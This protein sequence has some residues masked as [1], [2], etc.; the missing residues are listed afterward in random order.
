MTLRGPSLRILLATPYYPPA[1]SF[2]GPVRMAEVMVADLLTAGHEVT[3]ATTDVMDEDKRVPPGTAGGPDGAE[4]LRFANVSHRVAARAAGFAPR[5]YR[6]WLRGNA[7]RFDLV[8]L[9]DLYSM[10]SVGAARSAKRAGVPYIV[11]PFGSVAP[12]SERGKPLVKRAFLSLWGRRTLR[13][14]ST[15]IHSTV[16]ERNDFLAAGVPEDA[17]MVGMPLPL[18]LPARTG[19]PLAPRPTLAFVGRLDPIKGLDRMLRAVDIARRSVTGLHM[20]IVGPGERHRREMEALAESLGLGDVVTFR[21]FV[22]PEEKVRTLESA[23]A[24]C[25]LSYSE[26]LP[27]SALE[28]MTCGTPVILS[29]GCHLDEIDGRAGVVVSGEPAETAAAMVALLGDEPRRAALAAGAIEF[30]EDFRRE[31]VMPRMIE[32]FTRVA[33]GDGR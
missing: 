18:D 9:H 15:L 26:G 23:H 33:Q 13:E 17:P 6:R 7:G 2:G 11:Q 12:T 19:E 27:V 1:Y 4:V 30:A 14:A 20:D 10:V 25:L 16:H 8:V 28:S 31:T 24:M 5:G 32:L 3:V 21:G 29:E 22:E